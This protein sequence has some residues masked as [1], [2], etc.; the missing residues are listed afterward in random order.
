MKAKNFD[1][2][3]DADK[4]DVIAGLDLSTAVR[5]NQNQKRVNIDF[6]VWMIASLDR[7]AR[8]IGVT[9]QSII[10]FWLAEKVEMLEGAYA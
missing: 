2:K 4:K 3:F 9:R 8:R 6:P 10:R 1:Q 7:E 5:P